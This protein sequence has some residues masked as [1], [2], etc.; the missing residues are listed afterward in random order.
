MKIINLLTLNLLLISSL[1]SA[2]DNNIP[3][4]ILA[5][6]E[7]RR[8]KSDFAKSF[9]GSIAIAAL[10][11]T[12]A[13]SPYLDGTGF[14]IGIGAGTILGSLSMF[15][16]GKKAEVVRAM[17]ITAI[18]LAAMSTGLNSEYVFGKL[19]HEGN[20]VPGLL[21]SSGQFGIAS[22]A[23]MALRN[24]GKRAAFL[25][26]AVIGGYLVLE[27]PLN[28]FSKFLSRKTNEGY[29]YLVASIES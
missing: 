15:M 6:R 17:A 25:G 7:E 2:M 23:K 19:T 4:E 10:G 1:L 27:R 3:G 20:I 9:F 11:G 8:I 5:V 22:L 24:P 13:R 12:L 16:E 18:P 26:L 29:N 21:I 28:V 14:D